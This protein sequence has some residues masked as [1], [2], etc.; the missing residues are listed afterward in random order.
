MTGMDKERILD[1][2][3]IVLAQHDK[4]KRV[5]KCVED[6]E[7]GQVSK[8]LLRIVSSYTGYVNRTVWNKHG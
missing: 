1:S 2:V 7:G 4:S 5:M 8:Q 6:Y 3:R